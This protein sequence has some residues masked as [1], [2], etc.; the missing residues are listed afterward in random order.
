M[1]GFGQLRRVLVVINPEDDK[2]PALEKCLR[3]AMHV[4]IDVRL[5]ACDYTEYL[6][7]GY[8]FDPVSLPGL[9]AEYLASRK[10]ILEE[11]AV[12]LREQGLRVETESLWAQPGSEVLVAA[13]V[14][15]G[16]DLVIHHPNRSKGVLSRLTLTNQDWALARYLICHG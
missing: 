12:P 10:K 7:E 8:Y 15:W 1:S 3:V 4:D 14:R 2:H 9:R 11:L 13:A 16:A 5:V 6:V